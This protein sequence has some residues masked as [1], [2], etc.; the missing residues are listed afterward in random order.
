[1]K[2]L[3]AILIAMS[4]L[5]VAGASPPQT[6]FDN[7]P[8]NFSPHSLIPPE[9][10]KR[11]EKDDS[12]PIRWNRRHLTDDDSAPIRWNRRVEMRSED[13]RKAW[14]DCVVFNDIPIEPQA[15][16]WSRWF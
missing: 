2:Y 14:E 5:A 6:G 9:G 7:T 12:D 10:T 13:A 4:F 3:L 8:A 11:A 1:M 15:I 16:R